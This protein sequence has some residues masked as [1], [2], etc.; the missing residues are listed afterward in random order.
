MWCRL[1]Q[2]RRCKSGGRKDENGRMMDNSVLVRDVIP[3]TS[4]RISFYFMLLLLLTVL[5]YTIHIF[6]TQINVSSRNNFSPIHE[7]LAV[8]SRVSH[9]I[10]CSHRTTS[11]ADLVER[12]TRARPDCATTKNRKRKK[13]KIIM[14][15]RPLR[16]PLICSR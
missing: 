8:R 5:Q 10:I 2:N 11:I 15:S 7:S 9:S 14:S 12:K 4:D 3:T 6:T 13:R 1:A 16:R